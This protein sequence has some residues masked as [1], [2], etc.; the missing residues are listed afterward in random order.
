M[1]E[2]KNFKERKLA[3]FDK[4]FI[5]S[6]RCS[7]CWGDNHDEPCTC[8]KDMSN[9][10]Y[11]YDLTKQF[12]S[13]LIDEMEKA[14]PSFWDDPWKYGHNLDMTNSHNECRD[15]FLTNLNS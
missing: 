2:L 7:H 10:K 12:I 1:N 8:D 4:Q 13:D 14:I 9:D 11:I 6:S 15:E 3:E 5:P